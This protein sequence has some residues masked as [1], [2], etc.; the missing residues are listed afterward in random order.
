MGESLQLDDVCVTTLREQIFG[1]ITKRNLVVEAVHAAVSII[2]YANVKNTES[3]FVLFCFFLCKAT[4]TIF[5]KFFCVLAFLLD[6]S[7]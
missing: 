5:I 4:A 2:Y 1:D 3:I 7:I 6:T